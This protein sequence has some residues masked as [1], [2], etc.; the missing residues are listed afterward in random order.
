MT[1]RNAQAPG[2]YLTDG[3]KLLRVVAPFD[4]NSPSEALLED[5]MTLA[6]E[7]YSAQDLSALPLSNV[8]P[9]PEPEPVVEGRERAALSA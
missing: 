5:C 3:H 2:I 7:R 9:E 1:T 8:Q 4:H 6:V